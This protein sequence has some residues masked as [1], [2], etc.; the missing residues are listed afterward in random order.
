MRTLVH[1]VALAL[2]LGTGASALARA[3]EVQ[4][5]PVLTAAVALARTSDPPTLAG[6]QQLFFSGHYEAAAAVALALRASEPQDLAAH[7]LRTSALHFQIKRAL[8]EAT[9]KSKALAQCAECAGLLADFFSATAEGQALARARTEA[10]PDDL[11]AMF[12]LGKLDLNYVWLQLGTLGKR[13]GWG[14][15]WEARRSLDAVLSHDPS[16]V[17]AR[18]AR[19]WMDYI[20]DT[21]LP[22][23]TKWLLGGG[24]R[25]RALLVLREAVTAEDEFFVQV[26]ARFALWEMLVRERNILEA[27]PVAQDLERDFPENSEIARFVRGHASPPAR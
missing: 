11:S 7:E 6:G 14:E 16:H 2:A 21:R 25:K 5:A 9:N 1:L 10:S 19:A 18:V 17:R 4:P 23:G 15:Y 24:S 3:P 27:L 22:R 20:V 8:G 13:T 12:F 26:E